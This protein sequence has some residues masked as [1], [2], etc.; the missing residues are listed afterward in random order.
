MAS[1]FALFTKGSKL[2]LNQ[3]FQ[4]RFLV[5]TF[6]HQALGMFIVYVAGGGGGGVDSV[7]R[8]NDNVL[9]QPFEC[10]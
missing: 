8:C 5:T 9:T 3:G 6:S 1:K 10:T 2:P 7:R 4:N